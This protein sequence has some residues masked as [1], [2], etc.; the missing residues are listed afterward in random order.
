MVNWLGADNVLTDYLSQNVADPMEW[1]LDR[2]LVRS[3]FEIWGRPQ[4]D[5][6][7]SASNTHLPL[8]YS[9][10]YHP[11]AITP[12]ALLQPWTGLYAFPPFPLLARMLANMYCWV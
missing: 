7:L 4:I 2:K 11:E 8:W 9:W 10:S 1:S 3:L 5:L 6:F 12:N